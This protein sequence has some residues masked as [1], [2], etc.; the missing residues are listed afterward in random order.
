MIVLTFC[1]ITGRTWQVSWGPTVY[2]HA[3]SNNTYPLRGQGIEAK[4]SLMKTRQFTVISILTHFKVN[5]K[6]STV[7]RQNHIYN[8]PKNNTYLL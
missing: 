2:I 4:D 8:L 3:S 6:I 7:S 5:Q 1:F